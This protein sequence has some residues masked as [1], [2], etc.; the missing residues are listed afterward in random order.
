M[1]Y[2]FQL[3]DHGD[4]LFEQSDRKDSS[5][6]FDFFVARTN[7]LVFNFY[8]DDYDSHEYLNDLDPQFVFDFCIDNPENNKEIVCI[9]NRE[10]YLYQ[11]VKIRLNSALG[12]IQGNETLGS[13]LDNYRH[14]L[15]NPDKQKSYEDIITCVK[16]AIKDILPNARVAVYNKPTIYTDF[17]NSII[18]TITQDDFNYYY[19]L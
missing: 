3:N 4:I 13:T 12:T 7:G 15:L 8:I 16:T 17:C 1:R 19:Y 18:I 10:E 6:Q 14:M 5:L 2:D 9:D 11:Q